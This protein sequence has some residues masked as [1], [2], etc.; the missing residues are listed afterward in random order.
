M[1]GLAPLDDF[2]KPFVDF[3]PG[4]GNDKGRIHIRVH[5]RKRT[6][7]RSHPLL[8]HPYLTQN[9]PWLQWLL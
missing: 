1:S 8:R 7:H 2:N 6:R 5:A 4:Y 9:H 3:D